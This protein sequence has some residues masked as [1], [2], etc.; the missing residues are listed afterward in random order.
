MFRNNHFDA[1]FGHY[2]QTFISIDQIEDCQDA[3]DE[4]KKLVRNEQRR[5][6]LSI[7]GVLQAF[8]GQQDGLFYLFRSISNKQ[9]L[10]SAD[11]FRG[12]ELISKIREVRN[13]I[14]GHPSNRKGGKEFYFI[15]KGPN[16]KFEFEYGGYKPEFVR[17][18]VD[19]QKFIVKQE[20]F[21]HQ[22]LD[23]L[24][25]LVLENI[26]LHKKEF[27][28]IK[29]YDLISGLNYAIQLMKR[30]YHDEHRGFQAEWGISEVND[31][32]LKFQE[33]LNKRFN[34]EIPAGIE[35]TLRII[36]YILEKMKIW[37]EKNELL[38]N[39]DAEIF[40]YAF[41]YQ[42]ESLEQMAKEVD[43][44]YEL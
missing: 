41:D 28:M 8:F 14:V 29:L 6:I 23:N 44:E 18:K 26:E 15:D 3:I 35:D 16:S 37:H 2:E 32:L 24:N 19:L 20:Q 42:F 21:A 12:Y 30:G 22:V 27:K 5:S 17:M 25:E 38:D 11:F 4:F 39:D 9:K 10:K 34:D 1:S 33:E 7:Y 40:M 13:D 36:H 31:K 43:S